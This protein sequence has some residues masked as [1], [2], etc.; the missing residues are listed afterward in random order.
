[1]AGAPPPRRRAAPRPRRRAA[2]PEEDSAGDVEQ[3]D[4]EAGEEAPGRRAQDH[5][6]EDQE[7]EGERH[8][9]DER[10]RSAAAI[11]VKLTPRRSAFT[12]A[13]THGMGAGPYADRRVSAD[14]LLPAYAA[15]GLGA[16][17][18]N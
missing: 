11:V 18:R 10:R 2:E 14:F 9:R 13:G 3:S 8:R 7:R 12:I 5:P 4:P 15:S 6:G 17:D 16:A 1:R